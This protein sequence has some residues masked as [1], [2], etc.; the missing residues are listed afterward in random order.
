MRRFLVLAVEYSGSQVAARTLSAVSS[1]VLVRLLPVEDYGLFT[2]ALAVFGFL[3]S[4]SD[5]GVTDTLGFFFRRAQKPA[6]NRAWDTYELAIWRVRTRGFL[7]ALFVAMFYYV[8]LTHRSSVSIQAGLPIAL[9]VATAAF[10]AARASVHSLVLRLHSRFRLAYASEIVGEL[11]KLAVILVAWI[12]NTGNALV[13]TLSLLTGV[14]AAAICAAFLRQ[15]FGMF[16]HTAINSPASWLL[17]KRIRIVLSQIVPT[18]PGS[19]HFSTQGM[20][21][22]GLA[23]YYGSLEVA[24]QVGAIGRVGVLI[25]LVAGFTS[26]VL[27]PRLA[28]QSEKTE[29]WRVYKLCLALN[30][31]CGIAILCAISVLPGILPILLGKAYSGLHFEL[32]IAAGTAVVA[33]VGAFA[34]GVNRIR[35]WNRWQPYGAAILVAAQVIFF[36]VLDLSSARGMLCFSFFTFVVG[37]IY[38]LMINFSGL[39]TDRATM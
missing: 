29:F 26:T 17:K 3:C 23:T 1:L 36:F 25:G 4:I 16:N 11:S 32:L 37:C 34:F 31:V 35:G 15:R 9:V 39:L 38:Q 21:V 14:G 7:L 20:L 12:T 18:L 13:A 22:T 19:L 5:L 8:Y 33:S 30:A 6:T 28:N 24:A 27:L 10:V 2:I